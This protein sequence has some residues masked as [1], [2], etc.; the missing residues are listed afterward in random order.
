MVSVPYPGPRVAGRV[1]SGDVDRLYEIR[2]RGDHVAV[3]Q[4]TAGVD[5]QADRLVW[6]CARGSTPA[7]RPLS[8]S[9]SGMTLGD[10]AKDD[11]VA[12]HLAS[13]LARSFDGLPIT[14]V[15]ADAGFFDNHGAAPVPAV[16]RAGEGCPIA[17]RAQGAFPISRSSV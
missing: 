15:S 11:V 13:N 4:V 7:A 10:P 17:R 8:C 9:T 2:G 16:G 12:T 1:R 5:V 6:G 14:C 3:E